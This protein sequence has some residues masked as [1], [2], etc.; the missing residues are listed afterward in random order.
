MSNEKEEARVARRDALIW[1]RLWRGFS[2]SEPD[3]TDEEVAYFR[4]HPEEIE[5]AVAP[6]R[7]HKWFLLLGSLAGLVLLLLSK[8]IAYFQLTALLGVFWDELIVDLFFEVGVA[9]I[10]AAVT[11]YLLGVLLV[12]QQKNARIWRQ[13]LRR[14]IG[15]Q[16]PPQD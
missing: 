9:L 8:I 12:S 14:K 3:V 11:A 13:E 2:R 15:E 10:G 1:Q 7:I 16:D 4:E 6:G 5:D